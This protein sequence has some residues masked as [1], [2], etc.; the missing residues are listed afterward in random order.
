MEVKILND[1]KPNTYFKCS[2]LVT[3]SGRL[4]LDVAC[5]LMETKC[6]VSRSQWPTG[7]RRRSAADRLLRLRV[8]IPPGAWMFFCCECCVLSGRGLCDGLITR[9]EES[10]RLW[11]VLVCDL[12]TSGMRRLKLARVVNAR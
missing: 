5:Q 1:N 6:V 9:P 7:L 2:S 8:R 12:E 11:C 4:E 3:I 10:Y